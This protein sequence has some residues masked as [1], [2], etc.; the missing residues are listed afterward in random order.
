MSRNKIHTLYCY[1]L[2]TVFSGGQYIV[3]YH[4][5]KIADACNFLKENRQ[6]HAKHH[7]H[8]EILSCELC[9]FILHHPAVI[10][11]SSQKLFLFCI[12]FVSFY[13]IPE[14]T[15]ERII[16]LKPRAPPFAIC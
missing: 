8:N 6:Q 14:T 13:N 11:G 4:H 9:E 2:L 15:V 7:I 1:L 12:S 10:S 5:H 3:F 16:Y